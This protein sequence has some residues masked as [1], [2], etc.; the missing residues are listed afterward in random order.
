MAEG[1][2]YVFF[3]LYGKDLTGTSQVLRNMSDP[4]QAQ[5]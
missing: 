4:Y 2:T 5:D 3:V 1:F